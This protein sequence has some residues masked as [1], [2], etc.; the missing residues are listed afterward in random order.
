MGKRMTPV[1]RPGEP[2]LVNAT[3]KRGMH[4]NVYVEDGDHGNSV[5]SLDT[6]MVILLSDI[7]DELHTLNQLLGCSRFIGIPT[8]L[9]EIAANT[10]KRTYTRKAR[11]RPA[12]SSE[13][14]ETRA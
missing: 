11:P 9:G 4:P 13:T 14:P 7:R 10:K 1:R 2:Y 8:Q 5:L 12:P 6:M 3:E